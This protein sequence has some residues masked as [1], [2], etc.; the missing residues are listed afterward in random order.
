MSH[1]M[2]VLQY[3]MRCPYQN[4]HQQNVHQQNVWDLRHV[5]VWTVFGR[6]MRWIVIELLAAC[7]V[8]FC[9]I[10]SG[11]IGEPSISTCMDCHNGIGYQ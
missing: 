10:V 3:A 1:L 7:V 2:V 4:Q 11:Q 9:V 5:Y 6:H 8:M